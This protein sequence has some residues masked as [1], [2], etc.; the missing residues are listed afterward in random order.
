MEQIT[1]YIKSES[2]VGN[3]PYEGDHQ[4]I[5]LV[6]DFSDTDYEDWPKFVDFVIPPA[7][8]S[9]KSLGSDAIVNYILTNAELKTGTLYIQPYAKLPTGETKR[10]SIYNLRVDDSLIVITDMSS[11]TQDILD[12]LNQS[13]LLKVDKVAGSSLI[14]D[15][16]IA[17]LA[18]ANLVTLTDPEVVL[19]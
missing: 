19:T 15:S 16:E 14:A 1:Y 13:L 12:F 10:F 3:P 6:L 17:R 7:T 18:A 2:V 4:T 11:I 8:P 9:F 5:K